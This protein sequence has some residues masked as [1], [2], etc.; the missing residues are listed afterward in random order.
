MGSVWRLWE[1]ML[2]MPLG[3]GAGMA[4]AWLTVRSVF[5]FSACFRGSFA[6]GRMKV[7][8]FAALV[9]FKPYLV[10][11]RF[12]R[13]SRGKPLQRPSAFPTRARAPV[14]PGLRLGRRI[15]APPKPSDG[16]AAAQPPS[17]C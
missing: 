11:S 17:W 14:C 7:P 5:C 2:L 13:F 6:R 10:L 4:P 15:P 9:C 1:K 3:L 16:R 12:L 8:S